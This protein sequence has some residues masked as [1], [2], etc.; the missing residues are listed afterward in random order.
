MS[1]SNFY[2]PQRQSIVGVI[3]IFVTAFYKLLR[4]F[5]ALGLYFFVIKANQETII[6][7]S[8]ALV[9]IAILTLVYSF[10]YYLKFTF[11]INE[12]NKEF[13]LQKGV[14][15]SDVVNIPFHKIQQVNFKRNILQRIIGIY[16]VVIDTAGS[17]E[18][19]VEIKALSKERADE[20]AALLMEFS[21]KE[22]IS[23]ED[24][25]ENISIPDAKQWEYHLDIVTLIKLGLTSNYFRGLAILV[26]FY[27]TLRTQFGLNQDF[28]DNIPFPELSEVAF[29]FLLILFLLIIAML[30]TVA[31]TFIRYFNL[32]ITRLHNS[33]QVEMGLRNNT[34]VNLKASRVQLLQEIVNPVQKRLNLYKLKISL[35]SSQDDLAK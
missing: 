19:E 6:Y 12:K 31:E 8:L 32:T 13:V 14:F 5:W 27:S 16:S 28:L 18:E 21:A 1:E 22:K 30:I 3:L 4:N 26:A 34:K 15:S 17:G 7:G 33:L 11:F 24:E 9:L 35:A 29:S 10:F 20:L 23:D 2:T 25:A